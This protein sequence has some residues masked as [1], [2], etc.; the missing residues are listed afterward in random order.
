MFRVNKTRVGENGRKRHVKISEF[1]FRFFSP[2]YSNPRKEY[3]GGKE[4]SV[5][6]FLR[7]VPIQ[8]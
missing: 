3:F 4:L 2:Q 8:I 7:T 1:E 5:E 6:T